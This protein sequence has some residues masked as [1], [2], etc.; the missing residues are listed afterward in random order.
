LIVTPLEDALPAARYGG[1]AAKLGEAIRAGLPVPLGVALDA[2][3]VEAVVAGDAALRKEIA[4]LPEKLG[5][6]VAA[7][8]SAIGEDGVAHSFAGQHETHLNVTSGNALVDAIA[9]VHASARSAGAIAYRKQHGIEGAP[10]IAVVVQRL[11]T[12]ECAGVLF[13]ENPVTHADEFVAEAAWGLGEI[14]VAGLVTPD[15]YRVARDG[16]VLERRIGEKDLQIVATADGGTMEE[17]VDAE[18]ASKACLDD[19]RLQKLHALASACERTFGKRLDLEW[20]FSADGALHLLQWRP[21]TTS[22]GGARGTKS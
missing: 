16:R 8:S 19:A 12:S 4:S 6:P 22:A 15:T 3:A 21:I 7:R 9:R 2:D 10:K 11:V 20:A 18:R 5:G 17:E 1:K 13:T 14:V